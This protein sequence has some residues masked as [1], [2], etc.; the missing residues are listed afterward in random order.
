MILTYL[1]GKTC[2]SVLDESLIA[3]VHARIAFHHSIVLVSP[4]L[5]AGMLSTWQVIDNPANFDNTYP[6]ASLVRLQD[7][8]AC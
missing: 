3:Q 4:S 2:D 1:S 5:K 8:V 6:L 7:N